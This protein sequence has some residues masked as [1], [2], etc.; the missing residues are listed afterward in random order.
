MVTVGNRGN[1]AVA[2]ITNLVTSGKS[3]KLQL[4]LINIAKKMS[5]IRQDRQKRFRSLS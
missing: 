4:S 3:F 1:E 5:I 2:M